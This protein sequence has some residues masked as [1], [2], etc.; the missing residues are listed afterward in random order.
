MITIFCGPSHEPFS[1]KLK[2]GRGG[3]EYMVMEMAKELAKKEPV[4]VYNRCQDDEG[5]YDNVT[6][7]NYEDFDPAEK[8]DVIIVWRMPE[9]ILKHGIKENPAK[10]Y[11]WL[12]DTIN[13][14]D[15]LPFMYLYDGVFCLSKW[16][17][18]FY[19]SWVQTKHHRQF[20]QTRN[21]TR[22]TPLV[23]DRDPH[24]IVY[25]S[26]YNRGLV[27]LL[28]LWPKIK[29]A[30]PEAK[31]RIFYGW[32]TLEK[33]MPTEQ[34]KN[35][36]EKLEE[37][38][39]QEG[40]THLGRITQEEVWREYHSAGVWAYPCINF[41]E[42][43]CITAMQAQLAGAIPVVVP[44]AALMETVKF[45]IKTTSGKDSDEIL[46]NWSDDLIKVLSDTRGQDQVRAVMQEKTKHMFEFGTLAEEW[47]KIWTK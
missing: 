27:E 24:I 32:Q 38:M 16:H 47:R 4:R 20:I 31:L 1:P 19:T 13:P 3:S 10:K 33:I 45:G 42:I 35:F 21:A 12:H 17:R 28:S 23:V 37:M 26:L 46:S 39:N 14:M 7:I 8:T 5:T 34:F 40:I 36:K 15:V 9:L 6:Y 18:D 44:R 25:G 29:L 2:E 41:N 43:S 22:Y 30:V 11:L